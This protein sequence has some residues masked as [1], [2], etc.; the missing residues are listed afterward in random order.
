MV[1]N[2][3]LE[4]HGKKAHVFTRHPYFLAYLPTT[5]N[6]QPILTMCPIIRG[7][8]WVTITVAFGITLHPHTQISPF[9]IQFKETQETFTN[10]EI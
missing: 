10:L 8:L 1:K 6:Y 3:K 9:R 4:E 2:L 5:V 7:W